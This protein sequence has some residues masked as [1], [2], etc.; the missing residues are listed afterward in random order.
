V[1]SMGPGHNVSGTLEN[2]SCVIDLFVHAGLLHEVEDCHMSG[3]PWEMLGSGSQ[4]RC[5]KANW[6]SVHTQ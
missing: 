4:C 2:C 1:E 3:W 5:C 6:K